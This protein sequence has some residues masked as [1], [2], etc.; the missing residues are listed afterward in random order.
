MVLGLCFGF[1]FSFYRVFLGVGG[2]FSVFFGRFGFW[3]LFVSTWFTLIGACV[4]SC[5]YSFYALYWRVYLYGF[6]GFRLLCVLV[7]EVDGLD[8]G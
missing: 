6:Y 8:D 5:F 3:G 2:K 1:G 7:R 4:F